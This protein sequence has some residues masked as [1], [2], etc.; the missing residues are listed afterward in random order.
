MATGGGREEPKAPM[1]PRLCCVI[2]MHRSDMSEG[3]RERFEK[4]GIPLSIDDYAIFDD[5][6]FV[7]GNP[8]AVKVSARR[9]ALEPSLFSKKGG[10]SSLRATN[11]DSMVYAQSFDLFKGAKTHAGSGLFATRADAL[12]ACFGIRDG[13]LA[14]AL[15]GSQATSNGKPQ[16][17][18]AKRKPATNDIEACPSSSSGTKL[19]IRNHPTTAASARKP[20][21]WPK[22]E[23]AQPAYLRNA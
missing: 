9:L 20:R 12:G 1:T 17:P 5:S 18:A 13:P 3:A 10:A 23:V 8:S 7:G 11:G 16:C 15:I 4:D 21:G 2:D 19:S 14:S 6:M 22:R